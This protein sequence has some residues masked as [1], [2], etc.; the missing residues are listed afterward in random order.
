MTDQYKTD[1]NSSKV[2]VVDDS[3]ASLKLM[4]LQISRA[5][6]TVFSA[7]TGEE[8]LEIVQTNLPDLILLDINLPGISGFDVMERLKESPQAAGIPVIMISAATDLECQVK[9]FAVGVVDFVTKPTMEPLLL[10]RIKLHLELSRTRNELEQSNQQLSTSQARYRL[11]AENTSDVIWSMNPHSGRLNYVSP[12]VYKLRGYTAEEV[13]VQTVD[14]TL[15]RASRELAHQIIAEKLAEIAFG[16]HSQLFRQAELEQICKDGS[17][18]WV[19]VSATFILDAAGLLSEIIG[20][21]RDIT[22]RRQADA[23]LRELQAQLLQNEK[24]ASIGQLS[25]GIAHEINNP[26]GFIS[27]NL[28]TLGKYIDKFD[29]YLATVDELLRQTGDDEAQQQVAVLRKEL[30]LDYVQRD[31]HALLEESVEG[32]ERV[33][34]I[35]QDLKMFS[36]GNATEMEKADINKCLD[37]TINIIWNQIKYVAELVRDYSELPWVV[38]NAQQLNQV[39]LNL[40]VNAS[41]AIQ[42]KGEQQGT[43]T[44]STWADHKNV[45]IAV[46][47]TGCGMTEEVQRRIFDPFFTTKEVGKGTGLGLSI[48]YEIIKKHGGELSVQSNK[49]NGSTFT[50][51]LPLYGETNGQNS[52]R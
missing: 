11:I 10:A 32:A 34:K 44:V 43:V 19:E 39:F 49:E 18:V 30:K 40:L 13:L 9:G 20:V 28:N 16:D 36:H 41:H 51:R 26:I 25:A 46:R 29:R 4:T 31:I 37:S 38:C 8:A 15:T 52:D 6:Y 45:F 24:M 50:V 27:S 33:M 42:A 14:E 2:L 22:A 23:S 3:R 1:T 7:E 35:V 47:D 17:T 48:S 12:S 21:S 5:G